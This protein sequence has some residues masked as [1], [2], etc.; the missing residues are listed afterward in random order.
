[1]AEELEISYF[2][3][4]AKTGQGIKDA[5]EKLTRD[6]MKKKGIGDSRIESFS[7]NNEQKKKKRKKDS[8]YYGC[9]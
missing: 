2:E 6:I 1:M 5:F 9:S 8:D 4:S 3:T 7:L